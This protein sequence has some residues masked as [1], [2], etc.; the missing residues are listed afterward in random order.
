MR[1]QFA[2]AAGTVRWGC[3][4]EAEVA[5]LDEIRRTTEEDHLDV[6]YPKARHGSAAPT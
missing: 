4:A 1:S 5:H 3:F 6:W 2:V